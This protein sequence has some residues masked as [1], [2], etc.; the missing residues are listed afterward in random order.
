M[1]ALGKNVM[2]VDNFYKT[3]FSQ[4]SRD[5]FGF[6]ARVKGIYSKVTG[7]VED[8]QYDLGF[9]CKDKEEGPCARTDEGET[10]ASTDP[11]VGV[12]TL[13]P[14]WFGENTMDTDDV[15][16]QCKNPQNKDWD[17]LHLYKK[18]RGE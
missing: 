3:L 18:S 7:L 12:V 15:I 14:A 9:R 16:D 2:P 17:Y 4:K 6:E 8:P 5:K 11:I 1:A 13:C 10:W